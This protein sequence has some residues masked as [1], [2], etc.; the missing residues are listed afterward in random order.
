MTFS[1]T[2]ATN[3]EFFVAN[4]SQGSPSIIDT[5]NSSTFGI[6]SFSVSVTGESNKCFASSSLQVSVNQL[7]GAT[8]TSSDI[9]N[10]I[11]E[12]ESVT[13][14][15]SGANLYEFF[16][17]GI[18]SGAPSPIGSLTTTSLLNGDIISVVTSSVNG[19]TNSSVYAPI[20][21]NSNPNINITSLP[22]SLQICQG[23]SITFTA[24]GGSS[25]EFFVNNNSQGSPSVNPNFI[26]TNISNGDLVYVNG[27]SSNGCSSSSLPVSVGVSTMRGR[28]D[29]TT[30]MM[31]A[32]HFKGSQTHH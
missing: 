25:Y 8:L 18:S 19:C 5:L 6:G 10:I 14:T 20:T 22:S 1:A 23:D 2:G 7:P 28:A 17:N 15:S 11:C 13:Y 30:K 24:N 32:R 4:T 9:D 3:Y 29:L 31:N 26:S 16:I 12:N 27:I 21:V